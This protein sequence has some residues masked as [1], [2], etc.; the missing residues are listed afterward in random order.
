[1]TT[2]EVDL[3]LP[4][5][6]V[7]ED[8]RLDREVGLFA[9]QSEEAKFARNRLRWEW[10]RCPNG[11]QMTD[12]AYA[13]QVGIGEQ[14]V[15]DHARIYE[16]G[17]STEAGEIPAC[18]YGEAHDL[19][20]DAALAEPTEDE[21]EAN[22][23]AEQRYGV[24][25]VRRLII[26]AIAAL[27]NVTHSHAEKSTSFRDRRAA[28]RER[29]L[30]AVDP[31]TASTAAV[32]RAVNKAARQVYDEWKM[33]EARVVRVQEWMAK[34]LG[35][36][37]DRVPTFKAR[38][39]TDRIYAAM[40]EKGQN[41]RQAEAAARDWHLKFCTTDREDNERKRKYKKALLDLQKHAGDMRSAAKRLVEQARQLEADHGHVP[42]D[43]LY[44]V[45]RDLDTTS[46]A[47][48]V[49]RAALTGSS[50]TDWDAALA[51]LT[52]KEE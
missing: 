18:A 36:S 16:A 50:G 8:Q 41:W 35:V 25:E 21:V 20:A 43:D 13:D 5:E 22:I 37:K 7:S 31:R 14:T 1:M 48:R 2:T 33:R 49:T 46:D 23:E 52:T 44:H 30:D 45:L 9:K 12:Q 32:E 6:V 27:W 34:N 26:T 11:P 39:M 4:Q 47:I 29:V 19:R 3:R 38:E 40:D 17:I 42:E 51:S 24:S 10:T 15:R 28:V